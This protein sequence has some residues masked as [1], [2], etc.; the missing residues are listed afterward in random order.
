MTDHVHVEC[1]Y[2]G[3]DLH[4]DPV[5]HNLTSFNCPTSLVP[6]VWLH[7]I[8]KDSQRDTDDYVPTR[9][10]ISDSLDDATTY[11]MPDEVLDDLNANW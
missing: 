1:E 10:T 3:L 6:L 5:W 11:N 2:G 9:V 7:A 8:R 4:G